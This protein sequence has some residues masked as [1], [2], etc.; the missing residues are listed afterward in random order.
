MMHSFKYLILAV[1]AVSFVFVVSSVKNTENYLYKETQNNYAAKIVLKR[2]MLAQPK[3]SAARG[4]KLAKMS[5]CFACHT[6]DGTKKVGPTWKNLYGSKVQLKNGKM[7][8]AD[9]TYIH[10]SI[11]DPTAK[12]V[13]G[14]QPLMPKFSYLKKAQI[15]SLIAYIKTISDSTASG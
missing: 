5:G 11:V 3:I 15:K 1:L 14:F 6:T 7:V 8:I 10:Q 4:H 2:A 13:K 12:I 9:S